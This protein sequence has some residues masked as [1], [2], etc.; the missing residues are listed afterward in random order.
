MIA[1]P[2]TLPLLQL[3]N[4]LGMPIISVEVFS[5]LGQMR[6]AFTRGAETFV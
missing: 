3:T 2:G 1:R 4:L 6:V 5:L